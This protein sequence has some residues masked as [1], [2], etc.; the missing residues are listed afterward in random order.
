MAKSFLVQAYEAM[1]RSKQA[2]E[3][4]ELQAANDEARRRRAAWAEHNN[5]M[6]IAEAAERRR[7]QEHERKYRQ[8]QQEERS[9]SVLNA[10]VSELQNMTHVKLR[11]PLLPLSAK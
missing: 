6:R 11:K 4:A 3:R 5:E 2:R 9:G 10:N 8:Q 1:A 7:A